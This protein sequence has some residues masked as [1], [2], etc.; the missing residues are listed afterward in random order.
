M[1]DELDPGRAG[2][3]GIYLGDC[4]RAVTQAWIPF[5]RSALQT[6]LQID[7]VT[8]QC[9]IFIVNCCNL[10]PCFVFRVHGVLPVFIDDFRV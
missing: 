9:F 7:S 2:C 6:S 8:R 5:I 10:S 1:R 4:F 3:P